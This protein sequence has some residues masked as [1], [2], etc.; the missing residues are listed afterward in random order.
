[1]DFVIDLEP[2]AS[3]TGNLRSDASTQFFQTIASHRRISGRLVHAVHGKLGDADDSSA[4]SLIVLR[5]ILTS[6]NDTSEKRRWRRFFCK[7]RFESDPSKDEEREPKDDPVVRAFAPCQAGKIYLTE[8]IADVA[9]SRTY[10]LK[11]T[12]GVAHGPANLGVESRAE[13]TRQESY[14]RRYLLTAE[15]DREKSP[16]GGREGEDVVYWTVE[17]N[18]VENVGVSDTM[19]V[20]VLVLRQEGDRDFTMHFEV[21]ATVDYWYKGADR[22]K[23]VLGRKEKML[24]F[25]LSEGTDVPADIDKDKLGAIMEDDDKKLSE[26]SYLHIPEKF[27]PRQS[28]S[29]G[30]STLLSRSTKLTQ[31]QTESGWAKV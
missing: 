6:V 17:E 25:K 15:G 16:G 21:K 13:S 10:E 18:K 28:Y 19:Q 29:S 9:S 5:F 7:L 22:W 2:D 4:A 24:K 31:A 23:E 12:A 3:E 26:L 20:A 1:M 8:T 14:Q 11:G 30:K 27:L